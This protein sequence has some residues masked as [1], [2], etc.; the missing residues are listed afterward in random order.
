MDVRMP[1]RLTANEYDGRTIHRRYPGRGEP[2]PDL[3]PGARRTR[4][5]VPSRLSPLPADGD[6]IR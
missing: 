5:T 1:T 2:E 4:Q 6:R 3:Q